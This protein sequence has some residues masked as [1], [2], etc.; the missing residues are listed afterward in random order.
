MSSIEAS[1]LPQLSAM[2]RCG[3]SKPWGKCMKVIGLLT[4]SK[5]ICLTQLKFKSVPCVTR[6]FV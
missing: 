2:D 4:F 1:R 5:P 3:R 6:H